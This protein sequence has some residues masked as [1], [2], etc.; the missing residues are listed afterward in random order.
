VTLRLRLSARQRSRAHRVL[1]GGGRVSARVT[2]T[3]RDTAGNARRRTVRI[4]LR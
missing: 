3:A 4:P 2:L 1:R